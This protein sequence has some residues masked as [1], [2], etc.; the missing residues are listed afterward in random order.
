LRA[1]GLY[2]T[3]SWR[4]KQILFEDDNKKGKGNGQR[5][6]PRGIAATMRGSFPFVSLRVRMKAKGSGSRS[7]TGAGL[8]VCGGVL[9]L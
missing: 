7:F 1:V 9:G 4:R 3:K 2:G 6:M 8:R 5:R